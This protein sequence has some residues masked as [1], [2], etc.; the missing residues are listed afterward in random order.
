MNLA[1]RSSV[2]SFPNVTQL[3][4]SRVTVKAGV[5]VLGRWGNPRGCSEGECTVSGH[6]HGDGHLSGI[7]RD[8]EG[9]SD[10]ENEIIQ[11]QGSGFTHPSRCRGEVDEDD[12]GSA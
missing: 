4:N 10:K 11:G 7:H 5:S 12:T 9:I 6:F 3:E 8:G 1:P 2:D